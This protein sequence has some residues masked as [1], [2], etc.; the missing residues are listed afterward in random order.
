MP[1]EM[2]ALDLLN[3]FHIASRLAYFPPERDSY[4]GG[5]MLSHLI[6]GE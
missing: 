3:F 5:K 4:P 6:T 2:Q 1:Y